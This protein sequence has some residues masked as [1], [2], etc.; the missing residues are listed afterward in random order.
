MFIILTYFWV[1]FLFLILIWALP[2]AGLSGFIA[3]VRFVPQ[4]TLCLLSLTLSDSAVRPVRPAESTKVV[5]DV[6]EAVE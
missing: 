6:V 4:R 3:I 1:L 2:S 5:V